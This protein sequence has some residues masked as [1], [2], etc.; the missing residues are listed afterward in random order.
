VSDVLQDVKVLVVDDEQVLAWSIEKELSKY[1]AEIKKAHSAKEAREG[2]SAF[3][4]DVIVCDLKLPDGNG[5]DLLKEWKEKAPTLPVILITAH[6]AVETAIS[7][8][9]LSA[10]D[11][12]QKPF[13]LPDLTS[14]VRRASEVSTL[15]QKV[16]R[17]EGAVK[18]RTPVEIIGRSTAMRDLRKTLK[19]IALSN[20]D[21]VLV[22]GDTG[23]GKELA[24]RAIHEWS[25]HANQ[26]Y[27][28]INC[29][30][31]P[32]Q[33]LES[34]LFGYEKGAFTDAK[35]RKLGLFEIAKDGTI[36]LDEIGEMPLKLQAKLLRALE[37]RRFKRLGGVK[38][39]E[40]NARI[41]AATNRDLIRE[42]AEERFRADL[43]YRLNVIPVSVAPLKERKNDIPEL[44]EFFMEKICRNLEVEPI[45]IDANTFEF[46]MSHD[47]PGNVR[48]LKNVLQR[49]IVLD[50]PTKLEPKH[51]H[52]EKRIPTGSKKSQN[53]EKHL[54]V[55]ED[56]GEFRLPDSGISLED[57]E[58]D[59]L[60]Q[61][62]KKSNHNQSRAAEL[63]RISRHT[64]RYRLEKHGLIA[65]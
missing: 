2:F 18:G 46:L 64:L 48:E 42:I 16:S 9:R 23:V 8:V 21:T 47:W 25:K 19:R 35:A 12:L 38:D 17:M 4:P 65:K 57:L 45:D 51:I 49:A 13:N 59:L 39:I 62:L 43:Y 31:I 3:H 27:I 10:F 20:T 36:F 37:Y 15:R 32:E 11:Y 44:A 1:G 60:N 40:F 63:L 33:L 56:E 28:E 54:S 30:S 29:A 5:M 34:E 58:K 26:P 52:I 22:H 14:A 6:G 55:V 7:A 24:S 41:V 50:A 61:A 53:T